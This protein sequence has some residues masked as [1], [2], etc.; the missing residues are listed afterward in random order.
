MSL[1]KHVSDVSSQYKRCGNQFSIQALRLS[2]KIYGKSDSMFARGL[3]I[4]FIF[5]VFKG[6]DQ[7]YVSAKNDFFYKT[8]FL[9]NSII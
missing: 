7:I 5:L 1:F 4:K 2:S 3:Y 6:K 9:P 8:P